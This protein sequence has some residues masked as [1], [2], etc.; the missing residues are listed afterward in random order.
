MARP[1]GW[2]QRPR[3]A[4]RRGEP[5]EKRVFRVGEVAQAIRATLNRKFRDFWVEGELSQVS[6]SRSGHVYFQLSDE[7]EV[8][9]IGGVVFSSDRD[10][11]AAPMVDGSRVRVRASIDFYTGRGQTQLMV[12]TMLPA[13][14]G[15]LAA[16]F[17]AIRKRLADEGLLDD[18]RK[19]P[20][21]RAPRV[22]GVVTSITSAA[23]HDIVRVA[24]ARAPVRLV[25]ADCRTQGGEAPRSIVLA[26]QA[27]QRLPGLEVVILGRGGG[28]A[29]DL[30]AFNDEAVCRAVAACRVP[31]V[32]G[33][34]HESDYV[35]AEMVADARASTPSNA[36]ERV[37][38]DAAALAEELQG[39]RRRLEAA[40]QG[41]V[42][43]SHIVLERLGRRLGDPS[44][45]FLAA[46][47]RL[48]GLGRAAHDQM[49]AGAEDRARRLDSLRR[50]LEARDPRATLRADAERLRTLR[51]R[52]RRSMEAQL[53]GAAQTHARP[54]AALP[55]AA[56]RSLA[57]RQRHHARRQERL[58]GLGR[59]AVARS[60]AQLQNLFGRLDALS[61]LRVLG[62]GYAIA[63]GPDGQA[64]RRAE[65]V[66]GGDSI[67]VRLHEGTIEASVHSSSESRE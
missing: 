25:V 56:G 40:M 49:V 1:G 67:R 7:R 53:A 11:I 65:Q 30:W 24:H 45:A 13:G 18:A 6:E 29:E 34:G 51:E 2:G 10:A 9:S 16:R 38:P 31:V 21:P 43:R 23:L 52:L 54:A 37:V 32:C 61:P 22:V 28:S 64:L 46:H 12:K 57:E 35:L 33:V 14:D 19:R 17:E 47:R 5:S 59:P 36:A 58:R 44:R 50:R 60:R 39:R 27:I 20:L 8:A 63:F 26:L 62:R 4:E 66:S 48:E 42:D 55:R 15:D 3:P 41:R